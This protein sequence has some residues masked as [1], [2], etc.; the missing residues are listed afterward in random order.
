MPQAAHPFRVAAL[1]RIPL[2]VHPLQMWGHQLLDFGGPTY[3]PNRRGSV[4]AGDGYQ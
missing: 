3:T 4:R 2:G 1:V